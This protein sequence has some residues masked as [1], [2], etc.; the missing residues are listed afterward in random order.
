[1]LLTNTPVP[2]PSTVLLSAMVGLA[3]VFQ[4]T[5]RAVTLAP[6]SLV[7]LTCPQ[8]MYQSL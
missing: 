2:V 7:T 5:P 3:V 8:F 6:Q 4:Q 1:M